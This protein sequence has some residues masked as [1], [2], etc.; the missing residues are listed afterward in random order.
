MVK[1]LELIEKFRDLNLSTTLQPKK[2]ILTTLTIYNNLKTQLK[3]AQDRDQD[4]REFRDEVSE[5]KK[6]DFE[7][8]GEGLITFK[9]RLY[10]P[11]DHNLRSQILEEAHKSKYTIHP[12]INKMYQDLKKQFWWPGMKVEIAKFVNQCLICQKNKNRTPKACRDVAT[13]RYSGMEMG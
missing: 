2:I 1:E 6:K 7:I 9:K 8:S 13:T 4:L 11:N 10:V 5:G 12:G 3:E